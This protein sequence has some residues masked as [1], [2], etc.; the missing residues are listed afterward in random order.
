[1]EIDIAEMLRKRGL[2]VTPQRIAVIKTMIRGGHFSGEQIFSELKKTEP[3]ISLSTV[4]NA[5]ETL[6]KAGIIRSFEA[7]GKTWYE[8][9][10]EPHVNVFCEDL[11]DIV[12]VDLDLGSLEKNLEEKGIQPKN[13]SVIVYAECSKMKKV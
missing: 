10:M 4:Y 1:M 9:R 6:E 7:G 3:S 5:L 11:G 8:M 12:D 13:L 2:K